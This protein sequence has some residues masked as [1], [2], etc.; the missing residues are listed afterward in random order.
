MVNLSPGTEAQ[1]IAGADHM[2]MCSRTRE[3]YDV[4]PSIAN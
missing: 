1:E 2:A 4:L 3:L